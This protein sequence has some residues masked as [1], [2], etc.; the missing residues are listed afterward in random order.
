[1]VTEALIL[2][3]LKK[4]WLMA[5]AH[6][7]TPIKTNISGGLLTVGNTGRGSIFLQKVQSSVDIGKM[8]V[9]FRGT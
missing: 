7:S 6:S 9:K 2:E 4:I 8:T 5:L 3:N 1:M